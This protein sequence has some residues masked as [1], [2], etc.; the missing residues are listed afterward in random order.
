V[1]ELMT[2]RLQLRDCTADDLPALLPAYLSNPTF[3][4]QNEGSEGEIGRYDL[5]RWQRDW[6]IMQMMPGSHRLGCYLKTDLTPVG[7]LDFLEEHDDGF[8]WLGTLVIHKAYQR[9]GLGTETF[10]CLIAYAHQQ[11]GWSRLHAGIKAVNDE[12]RAFL[13][14]LGFQVIEEG[15]QQFA[16]G[17][18]QYYIMEYAV[19][20]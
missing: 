2:K 16:G 5:A 6:S 13:K 10:H 1:L 8:P 9:Q 20:F 19:T 7:F 12:G 4:E 3:V 15:S 14:H 17:L 11:M 18:Q